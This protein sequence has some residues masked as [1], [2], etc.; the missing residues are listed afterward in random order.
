MYLYNGKNVKGPRASQR[1]RAHPHPPAGVPS[2]TGGHP[3]NQKPEPTHREPT[4]L[5]TPCGSPVAPSMDLKEKGLLD[6]GEAEE[7]DAIDAL[8]PTAFE[9]KDGMASS[10][11]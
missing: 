4:P 1:P 5:P 10:D 7:I 9:A 3:K 2:G 8:S 11:L 6:Y